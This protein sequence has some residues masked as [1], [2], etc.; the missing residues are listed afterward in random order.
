MNIC[1]TAVLSAFAFMSLSG[2]AAQSEPVERSMDQRVMDVENFSRE[3]LGVGI[4]ALGLLLDASP[5]T[6]Y[7]A[8]GVGIQGRRD[9][10]EELRGSGF[11]DIREFESGGSHFVSVERTEKGNLVARAFLK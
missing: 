3:H 11:V 7:P 9:A 5:G 1:M 2:C 10:L 8:V 4:N 6:V